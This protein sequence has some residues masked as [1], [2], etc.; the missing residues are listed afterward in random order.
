MAGIV[1]QALV[2]GEYCAYHAGAALKA[3]TTERMAL[4]PG[5]APKFM[6][7]GKTVMGT[8]GSSGSRPNMP[9]QQQ[10]QRERNLRGGA[11]GGAG[12][13]GGY[14]P[15][16]EYSD[17]DRRK[18]AAQ[19]ITRSARGALMVGRGAHI[20]RTWIGSVLGFSA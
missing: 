5:R 8:K 3:L 9:P 14:G 20:Q 6:Q 13:D 11:H 17:E 12:G 10:Q 7:N 4:G 1:C 2:A 19:Q 16:R 18:I 15:G